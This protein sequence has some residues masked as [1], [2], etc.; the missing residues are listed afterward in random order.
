MSETEK[1]PGFF[2]GDPRMLFAFGL[3]T[4]VA[5]TLIFGG[6]ISFGGR[7]NVSDEPTAVVDDSGQPTEAVLAPITEDDHV[8]GDLN[9]AKVVLVEYSDFECPFCSRHHETMLKLVEEFGDD[10]A[11][12]YR[13]FPLVSMH[14]DAVPAALA[15]ECAAEQDNFWDYAD[16]LVENKDKLGDDLYKS[17]AKDLNLDTKQFN[18]CYDTQKYLDR[19]NSDTESGVAAGVQGTP[20]TFVNGIAISG[21]V[22]LDTMK[23]AINSFL[24]E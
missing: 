9:K 2:D 11:W 1:N 23:D 5:L 3:V 22:P 17:L 10:V 15:S 24:V 16:L 18:E 4:G 19:V 12:V 6:G 7:S 8:R 20:A 14:P 21:A 13:H